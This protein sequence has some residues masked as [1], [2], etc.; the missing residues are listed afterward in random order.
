[1][2][3]ATTFEAGVTAA[4]A[5]H[6]LQA[7]LADVPAGFVAARARAKAALPE[8]EALRRTGRDIRDHTLAH[9]DFYLE[10]FE[11]NATRAGS[12]VHWAVSGADACDIILGICREAGARVVTKSKSM[13]SEEVGLRAR[14]EA[15]ALEVVETDLGEYIIQIRGETPSHIIAPAIHLRAG[16][17]ADE[18][19]R[20]HG[21][22]QPGAI[23]RRPRRWS[24]KRAACCARSSSPPRSVSPAP[25][26]SSP[27]PARPSSSPTR[28]TPT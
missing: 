2:K 15:A 26:S 27:K 17:V 9:L 18:F 5:N 25:T 21:H 28:A 23:C 7:A 3:R 6:S 20:R 10:A 19:R 11:S 24:A 22:L 13:V 1:M 14:L 12:S 8:F 16:D 4:L